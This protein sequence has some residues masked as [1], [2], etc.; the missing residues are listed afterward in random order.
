MCSTPSCSVPLLRLLFN[1]ILFSTPSLSTVYIDYRVCSTPS[2]SVPLLC[3]LF[4]AILFCT[5]SLSTVQHHPVLYPFSVYCSTPSCSVP[6]LCLLYTLTTECVQHHPVLYPFSVYCRHCLQSVF[7]TI[8]FCTPALST[9]YIDYRVCSTPSCSVPLFC[10]LY[11]LTT[12][13]VQRHPVLY[14]FSVYCIH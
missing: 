5:P 4:N 3:L 11:T 6:L 9:V 1:T 13:C 14:P 8:L 12:E 10:L 2:C 7:N